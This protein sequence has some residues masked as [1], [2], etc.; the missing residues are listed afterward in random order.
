M[1]A[2]LVVL[3]ARAVVLDA[4]AVALLVSAA[5]RFATIGAA[6]VP[7]DTLAG[8]PVDFEELKAVVK[9]F[10]ALV[11]RAVAVLR[12]PR[13]ALEFIRSVLLAFIEAVFVPIAVTRLLIA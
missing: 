7:P 2:R 1:F 10:V 8:V 12:E 5:L 6:D 11:N 9:L 13:A 3:L 4:M